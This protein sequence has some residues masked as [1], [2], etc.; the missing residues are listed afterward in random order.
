MHKK[1]RDMWENVKVSVFMYRY[2]AQLVKAH[3]PPYPYSPKQRRSQTP[4]KT[5]QFGVTIQL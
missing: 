1:K 2:D 4:L 5:Q 3:K